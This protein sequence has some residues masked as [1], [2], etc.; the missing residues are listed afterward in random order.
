VAGPEVLPLLQPL[1]RGIFR[2]GALKSAAR[3]AVEAIGRRHPIDHL[4]GGLSVSDEGGA[5]TVVDE[6]PR[7]RT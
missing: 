4:R 1:T 7:P 6:A 5:L 3:D 2:A